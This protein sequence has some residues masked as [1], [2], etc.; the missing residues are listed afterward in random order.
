MRLNLSFESLY[1]ARE[2]ILACGGGVE[3]LE[4][5]PLRQS[6]ADFARQTA[7]LYDAH[8]S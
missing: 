5:E 6:V 3:V 7:A 2:R 4:P 8:R 1:A